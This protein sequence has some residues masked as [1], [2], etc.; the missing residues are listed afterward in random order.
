MT[1]YY[2]N[3]R[4]FERI[5]KE[6]PNIFDYER[7][8][9]NAMELPAHLHGKFRTMFGAFHHFRPDDARKILQHA[10]DTDSPIA[11]FE[12]LGKNPPSIVSMSLV[13]LNVLLF[14]PFIRPLRWE[15]LP[16]IYL[17]P[18]VPLFILWDG[19]AS[20]LRTYSIGE[21]KELVDSL[22]GA[23]HFQWEIGRTPGPMPV[24][25]LFG[26]RK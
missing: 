2:Q 1:D 18:I 10:V 23:Q 9:V 7:V 22:V 19:V 8:S 24:Q 15:V 14:T 11:I 26:Y 4:A 25:Y 17:V 20:I 6:L 5:K 16:F 13:L 3:T 21:M 12:P